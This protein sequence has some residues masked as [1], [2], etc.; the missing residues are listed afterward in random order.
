MSD[1]QRVDEAEAQQSAVLRA[2]GILLLSCTLVAIV[3]NL[4]AGA[5]G[6]SAWV[7]LVIDVAVGAA[8]VTGDAK[9]KSFA[10][11]RASVGLLFSVVL[12]MGALKVGKRDVAALFVV[13]SLVSS[14]LLVLLWGEAGRMRFRLGLAVGIVAVVLCLALPVWFRLNG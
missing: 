10:I 3:M 12:L 7:P 14:S 8:L 4:W 9:A 6:A 2:S 5:S 11:F 1:E 13:Q